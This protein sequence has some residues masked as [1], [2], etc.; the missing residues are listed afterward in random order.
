MNSIKNDAIGGFNSFLKEQQDFPG[1]ANLTLIFFDTSYDIMHNGKP[2]K[3]VEPLNEGTYRIGGWTALFDALGRGIDELK[4]RMN[5]MKEEERPDKVVFAI[6]T[7]GQENSSKEYA[8]EKI[9]EMVG[10]QEK[11]GWNFVFLAANQDAL[12]A[13]Q[14]MNISNYSNFNF[15][16]KGINAVYACAS[17]NVRSY[18]SS[19]KFSWDNDGDPDK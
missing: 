7:D 14:T 9:F 6:L 2:I 15:D 3:E 16:A 4:N 11:L 17:D 10:E 19:G 5:S 18:R 12:S 13:A 8:R 1:E